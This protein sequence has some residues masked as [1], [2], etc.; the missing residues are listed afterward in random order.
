MNQKEEQAEPLFPLVGMTYAIL[1]WA[2]NAGKDI[3]KQDIN[4]FWG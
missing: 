2:I 1:V 3:E 4:N